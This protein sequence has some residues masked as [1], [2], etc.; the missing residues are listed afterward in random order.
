MSIPSL[1]SAIVQRANINERVARVLVTSPKLE[2]DDID[3]KE[4]NINMEECRL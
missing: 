4:D 2:V 1:A 3:M